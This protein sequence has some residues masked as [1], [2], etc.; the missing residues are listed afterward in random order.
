MLIQSLSLLLLYD[1]DT[2]AVAALLYDVD[3]VAVAALLYDVE[4][5]AVA[6]YCT[7]LK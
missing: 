3:T 6:L 1:V 7:M 5:V 2:V 4:I